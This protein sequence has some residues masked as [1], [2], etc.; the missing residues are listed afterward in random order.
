SAGNGNAGLHG[1][2][3]GAG[4]RPNHGG[5][6]SRGPRRKKGRPADRYRP[7]ALRGGAYAG[8]R[9][10]GARQSA[11]AG[12]TN[13]LE[14]LPERI[15]AQRYSAADGAGPGTS[16]RAGPGRGEERRRA[17]GERQGE[18]GLLPHHVAD[19]RS[20]RVAPGG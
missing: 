19:F 13:R 17:G 14:A 12:S 1:Y 7:A 4:A 10:A 3:Y 15:G 8:G 5:A 16:G 18:P 2:G 20:C 11:V 6:L 9:T